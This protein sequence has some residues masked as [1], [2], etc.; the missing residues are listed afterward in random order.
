MIKNYFELSY[1][2]QQNILSQLEAGKSHWR[3]IAF[4][5]ELLKNGTF[6][7]HLGQVELLLLLD[8]KSLEKGFPL[9][10]AFLTLCDRDEIVAP[11][12]FPW[13]GFV[14]TFPKYRGNRLSEKLI[15]Y[16]ADLAKKLYSEYRCSRGVSLKPLTHLCLGSP[17]IVEPKSKNLYVSTDHVGLYEKY[18]FSFLKEAD[19]IWGGKSRIL[20]RP[21]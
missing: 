5:L 8:D 13:I 11:E 6:H 16:A 9:L 19:N 10:K 15:D 3:A 14:F 21:L 17:N 12:L 7:E 18:G 2:H 1:Q 4:L 20:F